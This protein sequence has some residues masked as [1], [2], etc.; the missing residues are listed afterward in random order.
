MPAN[1][2]T[3]T[4]KESHATAARTSQFPIVAIGASAGGLEAITALLQN[5]PPDTGMAFIYVQHLS[6]NHKSMLTQ[7]LS[8]STKMKVQEID[9]LRKLTLE[10]EQK[11]K[12]LL[13]KEI[14]GR[15]EDKIKF[16]KKLDTA[17]L[18]LKEA[19]ETLRITEERYHRMIKEVKDYAIIYLNKKG[20]IENW[21]EGAEKIKGYKP[22]EIIGK[23]FSI[24]YPEAD[25]KNKLPQKLLKEAIKTGKAYHEGWRLRKDGSYFWGNT[26]IAAIHDN[27][28]QVIGFSK[29]TRDLTDKKKDED[30]IRAAYERLSEKNIALQKMNKELEAF[31]YISSHDLQEPLR[32][33]QTFAGRILEK[34]NEN[35]S[36]SGKDMFQRMNGA[37]HRMQ[38]LILDLLAFS[39]LSTTEHKFETT[40]LNTIIEEVKQELSDTINAK[41]AVVKVEGLCTIKVIPFLFRQLMHN[42]ISNALKFAQP[43]TTPIISIKSTHI[44]KGGIKITQLFS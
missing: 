37:A 10:K 15:A 24:F 16:D 41:K 20:I 35:L 5:L 17:S 22:E 13:K 1:K 33:I 39:R 2:K 14:E 36:D 7:I 19:N 38:Q 11:E 6:P 18:H 3:V 30:S 9:A 29:V 25:Q 34:E 43:N 12:E 27:Q 21:N 42:L 44:P 28:K 31:T 32:K 4:T 26:S 23:H 8:K 40:N